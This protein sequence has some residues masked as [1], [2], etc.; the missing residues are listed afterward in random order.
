[1]RRE[2]PRLLGSIVHS[3]DE[4]VFEAELL[5]PA[6]AEIR[7]R[8]EEFFQRILFVHRHDLLAHL[9]ARAV[10]RNGQPHRHRMIRQLADLRH[11]TAG[12]YRDVPRADFE[13]PRRIE[14]FDGDGQIF[15]IGQR[16]AHAHENDVVHPLARRLLDLHDLRGDFARREVAFP[17]AQTAGAEFA[18][19]ST[20]HLRRDAQGSAIG[21]LPVKR[22]RGRDEDALDE[23][24][25]RQAIQEFARCILRSAHAHLFQLSDRISLG[26][27]GA[28]LGRQIGHLR[29]VSDPL[30]MDPFHDLPRAVRLVAQSGKT[31][32]ERLGGF[33]QQRNHARTMP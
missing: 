13:A 22:G 30:L 7:A 25:V 4:D 2:Q 26:Q 21:C 18:P 28:Q 14:D 16:F 27:L 8:I 29:E 11:Q 23:L 15:P 32:L 19:V 9:V 24:S 12:R 31:G 6:G 20:A 33:S 10:Q 17:S 3:G 5:F 1:M